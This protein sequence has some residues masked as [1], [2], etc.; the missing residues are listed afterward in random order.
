MTDDLA[1]ALDRY[2]L[3]SL[4]GHDECGPD[5]EVAAVRLALPD[6]AYSAAIAH[7]D[8]ALALSRLSAEETS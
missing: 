8:I 5:C 2:A 7:G 3:H 1:A 6:A 4:D